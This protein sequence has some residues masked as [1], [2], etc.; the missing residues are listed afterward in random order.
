MCVNQVQID[1]TAAV[2]AQLCDDPPVTRS[3][4]PIAGAIRWSRTLFGRC[5]HTMKRAQ[6]LDVSV[7][8]TDLGRAVSCLHTQPGM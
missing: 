5:R 1:T 2:Y 7:W 6:A 3:Q 4:P 8:A